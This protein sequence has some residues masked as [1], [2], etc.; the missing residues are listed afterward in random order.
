MVTLLFVLILLILGCVF[1]NN[2]DGESNASR[3]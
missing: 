1:F 3:Y 2:N